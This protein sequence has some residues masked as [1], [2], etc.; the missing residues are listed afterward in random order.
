MST[1]TLRAHLGPAD[2]GRE[3]TY[4]EFLGGDYEEGHKYELIDGRLYVSPAANYPHDWVQQHVSKALTLY[5]E[6]RPNIVQRISA[7]SRV[8]VPGRRKTTCP[9]PDFALYKTCP[10]GR[11]V[12][13]EDISPLIV[14]EIV[15]PDDPHKD[16][17][18][19]VDL[20]QRVPS[21]REYWVFD[22][23]GD[24]NGPTLT[25][26]HR[27]SGRQ[28]WK[29]DDYGPED[30]YTTKLLPGFKLLVCPPK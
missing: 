26:Y 29:T 1:A 21:I 17:V 27:E 12:R 16:Y 18:R 15:S 6:L 4:D 23:C 22:R 2:H 11:D 19:N 5:E 8:F 7:R 3:L 25:V 20:Y 28:K 14:V 24:S 13:W 30:V 9:E 10:P